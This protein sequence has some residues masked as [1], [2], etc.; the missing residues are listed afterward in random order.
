MDEI[1]AL[2][3]EIH[4][5]ECEIKINKKMSPMR[6]MV[7]QAKIRELRDRLNKLLNKNNKD[8]GNNNIKSVED[9]EPCKYK[10]S[11]RPQL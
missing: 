6:L 8:N 7:L 3:L 9:K 1:K 5:L 11:E 4:N 2:V 10:K